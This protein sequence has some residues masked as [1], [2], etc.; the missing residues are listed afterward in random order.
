MPRHSARQLCRLIAALEAEDG[1]RAETAARH[2]RRDGRRTAEAVRAVA[3][4]ERQG[5]EGGR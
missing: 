2:A 3:A 5:V 4:V 1:Y